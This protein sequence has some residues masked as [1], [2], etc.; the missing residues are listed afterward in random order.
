MTQENSGNVYGVLIEFKDPE[1]L[2]SAAKKAYDVGFREMDAF[3]PYPVE[4]L[5]E[6][7]GFEKESVSFF[8]LIG[9][10]TGGLLGF[11][12]QWYSNV[13]D[14]PINVGGRPN[15]SWPSFIPVTFELTVLGAALSAALGM[16][17]LNQLPEPWHPVFN[18][19]QFLRASRDRF[20]L[21]IQASDP[22]FQID[23]IQNLYQPSLY[24]SVQ[25]VTF[26][27]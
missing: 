21:C 7:I 1:A 6:A 15:L 3:T 25:E 24:L 23:Q 14:Y 17:V 20:F 4:G 19:P 26:E 16:L 12:M 9:G 22:L 10:I 13:I 18:S 2:I 5:S 27:E 8:T 11:A